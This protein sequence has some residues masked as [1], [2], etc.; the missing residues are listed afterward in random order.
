MM[1]PGAQPLLIIVMGVS[2]CGK[3]TLAKAMAKRLRYSFIEADDFHSLSAKDA[4]RSGN[5]I[6]DRQRQAWIDRICQHLCAFQQEGRSCVLAYSGLKRAH[7]SQF[8]EL[9]FR[10]CFVHLQLETAQLTIRL[11]QRIK[12]GEGHFFH[13]DLLDDQLNAFEPPKD[14]NDVLTLYGNR[15]LDQLLSQ[16]QSIIEGV[17]H[18]N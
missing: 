12:E 16:C 9:G 5:P 7:R 4:M 18:D 17:R 14:E 6:S 8:R 11:R 15:P 1:T 13:P 10:V 3:T 2:G